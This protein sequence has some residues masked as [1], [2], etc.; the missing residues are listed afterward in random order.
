MR[1]LLL[2]WI[3]LSLSVWAA[4]SIL[5]DDM[6][7]FDTARAA[8]VFPGD[9]DALDAVWAA[10]L[11]AALI[12]LLNALVR[13]VLFVFKIVTLPINFLTLGLFA[14]MVS[15]VMNVIIF[16]AVGQWMPGFVV[17][18]IVGAAAGAAIMSAINGVLVMLIPEGHRGRER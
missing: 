5:P 13:P 2:R 18:G 4:A 7:A 6:V 16:W 15:F 9:M 10:S 12:G 8:G 1:A 17:H 11:T 3:L 14:L